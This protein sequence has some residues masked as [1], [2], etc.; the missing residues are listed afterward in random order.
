M[1]YEFFGEKIIF[2]SAPVSGNNSDQSLT[3]RQPIQRMIGGSMS[4][5]KWPRVP[6]TNLERLDL[7]W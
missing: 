6:A 2:P 7:Y 5:G 3:F 1:G 4:T